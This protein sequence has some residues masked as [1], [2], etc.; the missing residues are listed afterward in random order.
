MYADLG[1]SERPDW[2]SLELGVEVFAPEQIRKFAQEAHALPSTRLMA[3][4]SLAQLCSS[5]ASCLRPEA[6]SE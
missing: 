4:E 3:V 1:G 6:V 2:F 5:V